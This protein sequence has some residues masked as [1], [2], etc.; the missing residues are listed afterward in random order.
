MN[1]AISHQAKGIQMLTKEQQQ[2]V[3]FSK[4]GHSLKIEAFAGTGKTT[5]LNAIAKEFA[6]KRGLY[7]AFNKSI[8]EEA[9]SHFPLN[10]DCR[11]A[12][13]LAFRAVGRP[14]QKR[15]GNIT[16]KKAAEALNLKEGVLGFSV[17]GTGVIA[18]ETVMR[19]LRSADEKLTEKHVPINLLSRLESV[20]DKNAMC[21]YAVHY[22][23]QLWKKMCDTTSSLPV[24]HDLYLKLWSLER[25]KLNVDFILFDEAQD[26][27]PVMLSVIQAQKLMVAQEI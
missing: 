3:S 2:A 14:Y 20:E 23:N 19:F 9:K 27:D 25:P 5:T 12:H 21:I 7:L 16:G 10:M 6:P 11:T 17:T 24:P 18:I 4:S 8:A 13:S 15:F 1:E 22:A 26:A